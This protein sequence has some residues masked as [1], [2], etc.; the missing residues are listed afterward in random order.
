RVGTLLLGDDPRLVVVDV[1]VGLVG[2][3]HGQADGGRRIIAFVGL[4]HRRQRGD[5]ALVLGRVRQ[6]GG[7]LAVEALGDE[8]GAAAGEVDELA[9]QIGIHA[10]AEVGQVQVQV[11]HTAGGLGGEV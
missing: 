5:E 2:Q 3:R 11:V 9:D 1:L 4:A 7:Q 10:G 8:A 6:R